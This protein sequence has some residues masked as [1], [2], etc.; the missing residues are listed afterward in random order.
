[1]RPFLL[2]LKFNSWQFDPAKQK[3]RAVWKPFLQ[4]RREYECTCMCCNRPVIEVHTDYGT[5]N[6]T[7]G[8][9]KDI[10]DCCDFKFG[11]FEG[12]NSDPT[13]IIEGECCQCG[14]CCH[15][16]CSPCE[17]VNFTI[18]D[19]KSESKVGEVVKIWSGCAKRMFSDADNFSITFPT[20]ATWQRKSMILACALFMGY[21][22][23]EE[24][25]AGK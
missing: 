21:R 10:W 8:Y 2:D 12:L 4:M 23:F 9:I 14:I 16:A 5:V 13:Y 20:D 15:C 1:M 25:T 18:L 7:V 19:A 6:Q 22:Y 24:S 17:R 11:I 3:Y